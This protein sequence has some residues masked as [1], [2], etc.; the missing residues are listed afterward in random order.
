MRKSYVDA[1]TG[2]KSQA[3][4]C[5]SRITAAMAHAAARIKPL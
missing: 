1:K 5:I 2:L 3:V 4:A